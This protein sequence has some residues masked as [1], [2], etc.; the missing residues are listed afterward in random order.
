[1]QVRVPRCMSPDPPHECIIIDVGP[2]AVNRREAGFLPGLR[3]VPRA[4]R[5]PAS[6]RLL[7]ARRLPLLLSR[8]PVLDRRLLRSEAAEPSLSPISH[9]AAVSAP[10][11]TFLSPPPSPPP[12]PPSS[13]RLGSSA[14]C[15]TFWIQPTAR[16]RD[17][18]C[19]R[20]PGPPPSRSD[21]VHDRGRRILNPAAVIP[22]PPPQHNPLIS[23]LLRFVQF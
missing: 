5:L 9:C 22:S 18:A 12:S 23:L 11:S 6:T 2:T 10:Y 20:A 14:C 15:R 8:A 17:P 4:P 19:R 1:M 21:L 7:S 3:R 16:R 13:L